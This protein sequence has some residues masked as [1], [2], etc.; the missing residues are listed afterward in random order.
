MQKL[1]QLVNEKRKSNRK[2]KTENITKITK[3]YYVNC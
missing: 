2:I 3:A 1:V